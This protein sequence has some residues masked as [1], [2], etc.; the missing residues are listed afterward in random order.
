MKGGMKSRIENS[1]SPISLQIAY[2]RASER[3]TQL[4][5]SASDQFSQAE[6][7]VS[8]NFTEQEAKQESESSLKME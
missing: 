8:A 4:R 5:H 3:V 2:F 6:P 1:A 7:L